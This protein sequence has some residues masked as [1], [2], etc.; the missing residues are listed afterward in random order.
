[1]AIDL[2]TF[3]CRLNTVESE[4]M[5]R[6]AEGAGLDDTVIINTCAVTGE[7]VRQAR[8]AIRRAR[9]ERPD[10]RIVVTGCAAQT[11]PA[12]FSAMPEV[13]FVIGQGEKMAPETWNRLTTPAPGPDFGLAAAERVQVNDIAALTETGAHLV[14]GFEGRTRAFVQVQN[15]CDHRCTFCIIPYGR[16][17]S[18]S[19][20]MGAVV[21][22]IR[23]LVENGYREVVLTGVDLTSWGQDL[24]G[25]M[26]L[27]TLVR[28]ILRHVP[29]LPRLRISSIDSVE[30][31]PELMWAIAEEER[32]MPHLH[33]SLQA[34]DDMVL[35]RMKRRHLR[36]QSIEFCAEV[37]RLRPD[38]VFG[39][40]LIAGFP[41]ETEAMFE[42]SLRL[43]DECGLTFLHVFPYSPRKGTPAARMPQVDP[44]IS[45]ERAARLR[46]AG[47]A[48]LLQHLSGE[49]GGVRRVL[50][51]KDGLGRTEPFTPVVITGGRPG[52]IIPARITG[53]TGRALVAEAA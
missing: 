39:A 45:R 19:V 38:M 35:K 26:H 7:A 53:H 10:A 34:G 50:I 29:E 32:L 9:R 46:A 18:R 27:G 2:V 43:V 20:P 21:D 14:E 28:Q 17:P 42:N 22:Q 48:R 1:M 25:D 52:E 11:E 6:N 36:A 51:E 33:L 4:T 24:P 15:G 31:D 41:T 3:G 5:R 44:R 23:R 8:Q 12:T 37:R 13:D 47:E 30:A 40:D 49:V 16:G